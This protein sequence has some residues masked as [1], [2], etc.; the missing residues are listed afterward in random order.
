M[1]DA[2]KSAARVLEIFEHFAA[3]QAPASVMEVAKALGYPQSSTS[4]LLKSLVSLGYM[5]YDAAGRLYLPNL[6][7]A[8]LSNWLERGSYSDETLTRRLERIRDL[9][10]E[11]VLLA[12][13][14]GVNAQY[15]VILEADSP[16]RFHLKTGTLRP[17]TR[18]AAGRALLVR[19]SDAE[20]RRIVRRI[21]A[22]APEH[23]IDEKA[24]LELMNGVR[25]NGFASTAGDMTPGAGV[26]AVPL[27]ASPGGTPM[28]VGVGGPVE[29]L[30]EARRLALIGMMRDVLGTEEGPTSPPARRHGRNREDRNHA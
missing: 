18:T 5:D 20:I 24:F 17:L 15:V 14:N 21:N 16:I 29:R 23:R 6:R 25:A 22:E 30:G 4:V 2:V 12:L 9:S 11:T 1:S 27:A 8:L 10:G 13:R 28:A 19:E 26:V 7:L 3:S